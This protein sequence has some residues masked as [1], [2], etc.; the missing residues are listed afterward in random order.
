MIN[1]DLADCIDFSDSK[2]SPL[3]KGDSGGLK[4]G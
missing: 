4:K 3:E 1:T 2:K